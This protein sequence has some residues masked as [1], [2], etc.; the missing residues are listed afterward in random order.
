VI[1]ANTPII[2]IV[3]ILLGALLLYMAFGEDMLRATRPRVRNYRA[4]YARFITRPVVLP[5]LVFVALGALM[6]DWVLTPFLVAVAVLVAYARIRELM[7]TEEIITPRQILQLALGFR[8]SYQLQPAVF[9]SL[10]DAN[11]KTEE[12]LKGLVHVMV[13]S[14]FLTASTTRAFAEF[15][16]RTDNIS[17]HQFA[18]ILEMSESAS[19]ESTTEALDSFVTRLRRQEDLQNQV[20]T[21]LTSITGQTSFI[22]ILAI[23]IA[24]FVALMPTFRA[25]YVGSL[26]AKLTYMLLVVIILGASY[27]IERRIASLKEQVI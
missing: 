8:G 23:L 19:N 13:E 16:K 26:A 10:Q 2:Q 12:P 4:K 22:Q 9:A 21:N 6:R 17:L 18:Y 27:F 5:F 25:A 7:R 14:F 24:F 20:E 11:A 15:R 3:A 1:L